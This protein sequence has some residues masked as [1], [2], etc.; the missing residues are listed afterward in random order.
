ML[1]IA[2]TGSRV[3]G[4][5]VPPLQFSINLEPFKYKVSYLKKANIDKAMG[6]FM[7]TQMREQGQL[8]LWT[9]QGT[10]LS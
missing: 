1:A 7:G 3:D 8:L 2:E 5:L 10:W 6:I 4:N 9:P